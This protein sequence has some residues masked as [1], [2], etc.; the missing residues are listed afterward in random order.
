MKI[1]D[2]TRITELWVMMGFWTDYE[3]VTHNVPYYKVPELLE[4][5]RL[6]ARTA[7]IKEIQNAI[8]TRR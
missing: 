6:K 8:H 7:K 2:E 4:K 5:D 1:I 3:G